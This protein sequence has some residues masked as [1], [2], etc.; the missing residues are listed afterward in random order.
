[1]AYFEEEVEFL[2][3][4]EL[5]PQKRQ[6][7]IEWQRQLYK[8]YGANIDDTCFISTKTYIYGVKKLNIG[9]GSMI[10]AKVLLRGL[11][12]DMG[13]QCSINSFSYLQGK[14]KIGDGVRIGPHVKII[15]ENHIHEAIDVPIY[16][17]G[18]K[19]K[20]I[21]IGDDV[22]IGAGTI[23]V[24]GIK[25]GAH[26]I[27]AAGSVVTKNVGDYVIVG[28]N[29][30]KVIKDRKIASLGKQVDIFC[31]QVKEEIN[32]VLN[33]HTRE[34]GNTKIFVDVNGE[35]TIR[36]WCDAVEIAAMFD[37]V[38]L[39]M[40]K[41][42]LIHKLQGLQKQ[43]VD[44]DVLTIGYALEVLG[45]QITK[46]Y[47]EVKDM[48]KKKW[49]HYLDKLKEEKWY[50]QAWGFGASIDHY[51]TALY[52]NQKYFG[53]H[54]TEEA[55]FKWL[56]AN[57]NCNTGL[58]GDSRSTDM[59]Q[60]VNGFYR[61]TRGSY[62][63]YGKEVQYV[64]AIID[65]ILRHSRDEKFFSKTQGTACNVLDVIHPLWLCA[66]QTQY[67]KTEGKK[68][69]INQVDRI[70]KRW[71]KGKGFSFELEMEYK[72]SLQGTEMWLAILYVL[73]DYI[74]EQESVSYEPKGVHRL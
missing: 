7:Q 34:I 22:W 62:A 3:W 54:G 51:A 46:P 63:Q 33:Y 69:A 18:N 2:P 58:W 15:G 25:I 8:Q 42:D 37:T 14:I 17:Q 45:A 30:A 71:Q 12:L 6:E 9:K 68:W 56:N 65:T 20:G 49:K 16:T 19:S 39:L 35:E 72:A 23:I 21:E 26:S 47:T 27:I 10:G 36:A 55:L 1:M 50:E 48:D 4:I 5:T 43:T 11:E 29:P 70:L 13:Q 59:L 52:F 32:E 41:E 74:G 61:L 44:Y 24:D 28:G 67:R 57:Q 40:K 38:P 60:Q 53:G 73:M 66:K 31:K 64:D